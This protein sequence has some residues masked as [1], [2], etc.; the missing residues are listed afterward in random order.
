MQRRIINLYRGS[1]IYRKVGIYGNESVHTKI[2]IVIPGPR[3]LLSIVPNMSS[4][5]VLSSSIDRLRSSH[6]SGQKFWKRAVSTADL[7]AWNV[8]ANGGG[9][10]ALQV[11]QAEE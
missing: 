8:F 6:K 11:G 4:A 3:R 10:G 1:N 7:G 2:G 5:E 9:I